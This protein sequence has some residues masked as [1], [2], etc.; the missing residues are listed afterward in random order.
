MTARLTSRRNVTDVRDFG[1]GGYG[2]TDDSAAIQAAV[3][4]LGTTGGVVLFP[5]GIYLLDDDPIWLPAN[6]AGLTVLSGYG[7]T[8]KLTATSQFFCSWTRGADYDTFN[9]WVIEGFDV[10]CDNITPTGGQAVIQI[11]GSHR[12]RSNVDDI[13]IR[14]IRMYNME[15]ATSGNNLHLGISICSAHLGAAEAT[16]SVIQNVTI[17][18]V[19]VEGG[20][21]GITVGGEGGVHNMNI[22]CDNITLRDCYHDTGLRHA[23]FFAAANFH[24][25]VWARGNRCLI[26]NCVGYGSGDVGIELDNWSQAEVRDTVIEDAYSACFYLT[27]SNHPPGHQV[28]RFD[29][30]EARHVSNTSG[31]SAHGRGFNFAYLEGVP[32]GEVILDGCAFTKLTTG[33]SASSVT[34]AISFSALPIE[35]LTV[36]DFTHT[37]TGWTQAA[38]NVAYAPFQMGFV[39]PTLLTIDGLRST[40]VGTCDTGYTFNYCLLYIAGSDVL[41]DVRRVSLDWNVT[42][43][44][45]SALV[46]MRIGDSTTSAGGTIGD[47]RF[48]AMEDGATPYGVIIAD[49]A[50]LTIQ[51]L[52]RVADCDFSRMPAGGNEILVVGVTNTALTVLRDNALIP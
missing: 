22:L 28:V 37:H 44:P 41:M 10:D 3:D 16:Q 40:V 39:G 4:S 46:G 11:H 2:V 6:T 27:N 8:I 48:I 13:L 38:G 35:A 30:C 25:G 14:D 5:P 17:E 12:Q 1:A 52:M 7:A 24:L 26:E 51:G 43:S 33:L 18:R 50:T 45:T 15:C 20:I 21:V 42:D 36:R 29:R 49:S 23:T 19:R 9:H 32:I 47:L 31:A 34:D